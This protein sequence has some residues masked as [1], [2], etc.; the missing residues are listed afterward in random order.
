M[1]D[2]RR[3]ADIP[4]APEPSASPTIL[5]VDADDRTRQSLV[6]IL[7]IRHR[8][9]VVGSAGHADA[10]IALVSLHHPDVVVLDPRLP[11]LPDGVA[12]IARIRSVHPSVRI[13]TVGWSPDLEPDLL[14]AGADG[15]ARKTLKPGEL[16][17]AIA[18]CLEPVT[19]V[20]P[21]SPLPDVP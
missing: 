20:P 11:E 9:G 18:R 7:G 16:S 17:D 15:F 21:I 19:P 13:L 14:A 4:A 12:L 2:R 8:F 5:V 10:A 6:G 3:A 1:S